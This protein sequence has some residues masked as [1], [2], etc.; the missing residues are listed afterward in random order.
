MGM[1]CPTIPPYLTGLVA[2]DEPCRLALRLE[3]STMAQSTRSTRS[4]RN[5]EI[6]EPAVE[7]SVFRVAIAE[8]AGDASVR[9][10]TP[11]SVWEAPHV[12]CEVNQITPL[13]TEEVGGNSLNA[14]RLYAAR[15]NRFKILEKSQLG[16]E[17]RL[18]ALVICGLPDVDAEGGDTDAGDR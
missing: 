16:V 17:I 9:D 15:F 13:S 14:C 1:F 18:W 12:G 7:R 3:E 8:M 10:W 5:V 4:S 2:L 11:S 6:T